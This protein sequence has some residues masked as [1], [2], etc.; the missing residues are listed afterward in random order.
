MVAVLPFN[1]MSGDAEQEYFVDGITE[2]IITALSNHRWLRVAAC[3]STYGFK[4]QS[5]DIKQVAAQLGAEYV[6]EGSVRRGGGRVR[7]TAQLIDAE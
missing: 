5:P 4:G 2:D 7:V 6:V 1:N 3:N